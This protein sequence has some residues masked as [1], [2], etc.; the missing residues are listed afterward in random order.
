MLTAAPAFAVAREFELGNLQPGR[1][2]DLSVFSRDWLTAT[3]GEILR[4]KCQLTLVD[5]QIAYEA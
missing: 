1:R 2:A 3:P 5:G 4:S